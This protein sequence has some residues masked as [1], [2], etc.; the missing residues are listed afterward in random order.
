MILRSSILNFRS[1]HDN[2]LG[3]GVFKFYGTIASIREGFLTHT[4][5][6]GT[7]LQIEIRPFLVLQRQPAHLAI[8]S[9]VRVFKSAMR[10]HAS[11]TSRRVTLTMGRG[12]NV[13]EQLGRDVFVQDTS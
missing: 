4:T 12:D 13:I 3:S 5:C 11:A 10:T 9:A 6:Y 2:Q 1:Y 7:L 8:V